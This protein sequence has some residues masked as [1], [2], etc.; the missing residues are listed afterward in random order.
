M[1][2]L[3]GAEESRGG[4]PEGQSAT[5]PCFFGTLDNRSPGHV[6]QNLLWKMRSN[7][8]NP[9]IVTSEA[10]YPGKRPLEIHFLWRLFLHCVC[11]RA[12]K[13]T[14]ERKVDLKYPLGKLRERNNYVISWV[15]FFFS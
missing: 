10:L 7:P 15:F 14:R 8:E 1:R 9:S 6:E 13:H 4:T 5:L 2:S 3:W 12:S 11:V